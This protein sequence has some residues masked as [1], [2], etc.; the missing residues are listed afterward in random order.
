MRVLLYFFSFL[1]VCGCVTQKVVDTPQEFSDYQSCAIIDSDFGLDDIRALS[2]ILPKYNYSILVATEGLTRTEY[3]VKI[4]ETFLQT[5]INRF[6][7]DVFEGKKTGQSTQMDWLNQKR[8]VFETMNGYLPARIPASRPRTIN[9]PEFRSQINMCKKITLFLLGPYSSFHAYKK[10]LEGKTTETFAYG[11]FPSPKNKKLGFNCE[12]DKSACFAL[13]PHIQ[14]FNMNFFKLSPKFS[15][16]LTSQ[17]LMSLK[18]TDLEKFIKDVHTAKTE[19]WDTPE[20]Q[21]W[22]DAVGL[23]LYTPEKYQKKG[24]QFYPKMKPEQFRMEWKSAMN[25]AA[26]N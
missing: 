12:Y 18:D 6:N 10:E 13:M 1:I 22:D 2:L 8:E 21:M 11:T 3:G 16:Y 9:D 15:Y 4:G 5:F 7:G 17:E 14:K 26:M 19:S 25:S 24:R 23:Y 20:V